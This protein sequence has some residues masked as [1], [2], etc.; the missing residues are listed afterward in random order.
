MFRLW[1]FLIIN[2]YVAICTARKNKTICTGVN[3]DAPMKEMMKETVT[4]KDKT[5]DYFQCHH[6]G[7][8]LQGDRAMALQVPRPRNCA[9]LTD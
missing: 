9:Q 6:L 7:L 5:E 3:A 8:E 2:F 1:L 4:V